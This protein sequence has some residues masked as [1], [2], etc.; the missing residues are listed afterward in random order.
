MDKTQIKKAINKAL[1]DKKY[2]G[3][4]YERIKH[5]GSNATEEELRDIKKQACS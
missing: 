3:L 4:L 2:A 5:G 1:S